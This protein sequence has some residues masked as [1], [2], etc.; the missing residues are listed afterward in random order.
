MGRCAP[1]LSDASLL[2]TARPVAGIASH[3]TDE[4]WAL[5]KWAIDI[6]LDRLAWQKRPVRKTVRLA[7][8]TQSSNTDLAR[9]G[10][11]DLFSK[12]IWFRLE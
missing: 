6:R 3:G 11:V 12:V 8:P 7:C 10:R 1:C 4:H 9:L 2:L 5:D